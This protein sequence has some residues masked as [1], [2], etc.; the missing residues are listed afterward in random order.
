MRIFGGTSG[1]ANT[2][3]MSGGGLPGG[4]APGH[5]RAAPFLLAGARPRQPNAFTPTPLASLSLARPPK[6]RRQRSRTS[7][8]RNSEVMTPQLSV[9]GQESND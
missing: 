9:E 8:T 4:G 5:I 3:G 6:V 2:G 7:Y 1:L